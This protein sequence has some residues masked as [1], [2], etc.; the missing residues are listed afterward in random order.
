MKYVMSGILELGNTTFR[1]LDLFPSSGEG[2]RH[3]L[4]LCWVPLEK[5]NFDYWTTHF[6]ITTAIQIPEVR[7]CQRE[8][9]GKHAIKIV[10]KDAQ[11]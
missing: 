1:K 4:L 8:I 9:T 6:N 7:L 2:G 10:I 11:V 5:A 3:L